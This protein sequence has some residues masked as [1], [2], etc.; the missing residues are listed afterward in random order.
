MIVR[1]PHVY[2]PGT[3]ETS[4]LVKLIDSGIP[5]L[6]LGS[7]NNYKSFISIDNLVDFLCLASLILKLLMKYF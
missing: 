6:A 1:A 7:I 3:K 2:G 4:R 5:L